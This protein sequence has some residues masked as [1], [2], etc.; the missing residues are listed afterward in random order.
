MAI[1]CGSAKAKPIPNLWSPPIAGIPYEK[2]LEIHNRH[3]HE[4]GDLPGVESVGLGAE[5][6]N[7][8]TTRPE[9][10][11]HQVEGLKVIS[12]PVPKGVIGR[13]SH[14]YTTSVRPLHGAVMSRLFPNNGP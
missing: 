3:V 4:L 9:L 8:Y 2:A 6:I 1:L 5:G 12:R 7:V 10:V 11:P 14:T 13:I